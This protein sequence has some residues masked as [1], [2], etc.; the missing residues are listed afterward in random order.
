M[1][2]FQF[3]LFIEMADLRFKGLIKPSDLGIPF[4]FSKQQNSI[5]PFF[6]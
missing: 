1:Q 4:P 6:Y 5:D 3:K 2:D